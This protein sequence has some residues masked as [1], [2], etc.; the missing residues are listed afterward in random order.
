MDGCGYMELKAYAKINL[1]I[2]ILRKRD[3]GY[4]DVRMIMQ[5]IS[6]HDILNFGI[7]KNDIKLYCTEPYVPCDSRNIVYKALELIKSRYHVSCGMEVDIEKRIPVAAGLAGGSTDGAAAII[8]ANKLWNLNM[9]YEDMVDIGRRVG[10]DVPFCIRGGS[11]LAEG[12]GEKITRLPFI[13]EVHI[14][15]AKPPIGVSTKEVYQGLKLDEITKRPDIDRIIKALAE[16]NVRY[17][18]DNMVNVLETVTIKKYPV[19]GEIKSIMIQFGALGSLMSGSGPTVFGL[20]Q[21]K[22][23]AEKCYHRLQDYIKEVYMVQTVP[24]VDVI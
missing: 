9:S 4:H 16:G 2:D 3:D 14:V 8:A 17:V 21:T 11:A 7:R 18:A 5:S 19:I 23:C 6:L 1:S 12:I 13:G 15:L 22:E 10:A 20:F 24:G